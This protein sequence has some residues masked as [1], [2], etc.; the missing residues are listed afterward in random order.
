MNKEQK[1]SLTY[2]LILH[3]AREKLG[4]TLN[5]YAVADS[6]YHL[7]NN[8]R[9]QVKDWCSASKEYLGQIVGIQRWSI[10]QII[11]KLIQDKL[12]EKD[13]TTSFLRTTVKWYDHVVLLRLKLL[14]TDKVCG[15]H[16]PSDKKTH[17]DSH[18]TTHN[19]NNKDINKIDF[20]LKEKSSFIPT[21]D[22][23]VIEDDISIEENVDF[24]T[25]EP[26]VDSLGRRKDGKKPARREQKNKIAL[27]IQQK[28][29]DVA[30]LETG[31]RPVKNVAGYFL[32][33]NAMNKG[34]LS[35]QQIYQLF[36]DW[37]ASGRPDEELVQITRCLSDIQVN[38]WKVENQ[39]P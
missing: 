22:D 6:I 30:Q 34:N 37:F 7:S 2:T 23:S 32:I 16:T 26:L 19:S 31:T 24:D 25:G 15:K 36:N 18:E 27:R 29:M 13:P 35:E 20:S 12:V 1:E 33:L 9:S 4:L 8:P 3:Q 38:A 5:E 39:I 17:T 11:K 28:F 14:K 10:H 21:S